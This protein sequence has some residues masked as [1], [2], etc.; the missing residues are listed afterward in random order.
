MTGG[1]METRLYW[2]KRLL[3]GLVFLA[4]CK[5]NET[6]LKRGAINAKQSRTRISLKTKL[7]RFEH[8]KCK[9][10]LS[11]HAKICAM[12]FA[13]T[14]QFNLLAQPRVDSWASN[15][16]RHGEWVES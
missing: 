5:G 13:S 1:Q 14:P 7:T 16:V 10:A 9:S 6:N 2:D 3:S 15:N 4:V 8:D 12:L 11:S